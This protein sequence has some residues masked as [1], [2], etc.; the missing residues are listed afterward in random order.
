MVL[1]GRFM[2]LGTYL[3]AEDDLFKKFTDHRRVKVDLY[4]FAP[5]TRCMQEIRRLSHQQSAD[6]EWSSSQKYKE[7]RHV[8]SHFDPVS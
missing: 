8:G 3:K 7:R 2:E 4:H 1:E 5:D 6:C